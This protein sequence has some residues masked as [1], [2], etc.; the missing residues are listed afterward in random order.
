ME[1]WLIQSI[2][3][4]VFGFLKEFRPED[5]YTIQYLTQPPMNFT[6]DEVRL[7]FRIC[8]NKISVFLFFFNYNF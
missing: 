4:S 8:S 3:I 1:N 5:P 2:W 6:N 7:Y